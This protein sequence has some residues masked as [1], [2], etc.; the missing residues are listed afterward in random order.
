[1]TRDDLVDDLS[2]RLSVPKKDVERIL[3]SALDT[4]IDTLVAGKTVRLSGF[5][6]FTTSVRSARRGVNPRKP[7]ERIQVPA[8]RIPKFYAGKRLKERVKGS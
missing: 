5:G 8:V 7:S 4:I 3:L 6:H 2:R 1:M